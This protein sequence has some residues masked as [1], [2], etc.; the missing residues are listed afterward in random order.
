MFYMTILGK[1]W[2][3]FNS[4][5]LRFIGY[6]CCKVKHWYKGYF[7]LFRRPSYLALTHVTYHVTHPYLAFPVDVVLG[8]DIVYE[9]T[10][11]PALILVIKH[12]LTN[13]FLRRAVQSYAS[14]SSSSS[15]RVHDET[16]KSI[17]DLETE[18]L[19]TLYMENRDLNIVPAYRTRNAFEAS[20]TEASSHSKEG[21]IALLV[22]AIRKTTTMDFFI[23]CA[24]NFG[25]VMSKL[26]SLKSLSEIKQLIIFT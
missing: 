19:N 25:L 9:P 18:P 23:L 22:F 24:H 13:S 14:S 3:V 20:P 5:T 12:F 11:V 4:N 15:S 10:V 8:A 7:Q 6:A 16:E 21:A 2:L 17:C 26:F 1:P